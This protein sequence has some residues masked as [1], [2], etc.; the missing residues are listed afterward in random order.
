MLI[1]CF[2]SHNGSGRSGLDCSHLLSNL[3]F[4]DFLFFFFLNILYQMH[5]LSSA[6]QAPTELGYFCSNYYD[7]VG[8]M[9]SFFSDCLF[10]FTLNC[11]LANGKTINAY[12]MSAC[13]HK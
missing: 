7:H 2:F 11:T 12:I 13:L 8:I 9:H 1:S 5:I 3:A 4:A 6:L 10:L